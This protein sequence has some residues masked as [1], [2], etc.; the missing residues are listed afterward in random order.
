[1]ISEANFFIRNVLSAPVKAT[2][3][4]PDGTIDLENIIAQNEEKRILLSGTD[5]SLTICTQEG[6]DTKGCQMRFVSA[7]DLDVTYSRSNATWTVKIKPNQLDPIAPSTVNVL[8]GPDE[9]IS[10]P[11]PVTTTE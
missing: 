9:P 3:N 6:F 2:R 5:V 10:S 7:V 11:P 1:M 4:L 8:I